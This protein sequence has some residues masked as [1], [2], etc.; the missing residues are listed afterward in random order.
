MFAV[1]AKS[2]V[3]PNQWRLP[4]MTVEKATFNGP[5]HE[6]FLI[7]CATTQRPCYEVNLRIPSFLLTLRLAR[8]AGQAIDLVICE[9][10]VRGCQLYIDRRQFDRL[11]GAAKRRFTTELLKFFQFRH[12]RTPEAAS[13][14]DPAP[15]R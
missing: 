6:Q 3:S 1:T 4:K 10:G 14:S 5:T 15:R 9:A 8:A 12:R 13:R 11:P 2:D 7:G